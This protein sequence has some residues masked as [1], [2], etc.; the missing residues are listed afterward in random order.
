[1]S[2]Y[3]ITAQRLAVV[4]AAANWIG[5]PYHHMGRVRGVGAD[6]ITMLAG[7]FKDARIGLPDIEVP[8]YPPDWH[9]HRDAERYMEGLFHYCV[10]VPGLKE[11]T[12]LPGDI[13]VFMFGR[14][15]SHGAVV[16]EW[17]KLIHAYL[18]HGCRR[19]V[20]T[21]DPSLRLMVERKGDP[22]PLKVFSLRQW[23]A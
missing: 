11:R 20:Y 7:A 2:P 3:E 10:E 13:V 4:Q 15:Y 14:C 9:L 1:M 16:E 6:C 8:H 22:R 21:L 23:E 17:P 5:T 12:P 18:R 19:V